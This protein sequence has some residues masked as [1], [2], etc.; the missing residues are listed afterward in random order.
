MVSEE[1]N[2][3]SLRR[4]ESGVRFQMAFHRE[5]RQFSVGGDLS[6]STG[7]AAQ[8]PKSSGSFVVN[9][10]MMFSAEREARLFQKEGGLQRCLHGS[11]RTTRGRGS[12]DRDWIAEEGN[13]IPTRAHS[14]GMEDEDDDERNDLEKRDVEDEGRI[15]QKDGNDD[16]QNNGNSSLHCRS[17]KV[18]QD[19]TDLLI[20][21]SSSGKKRSFHILHTS[22]YNLSSGL[23]NWLMSRFR[24]QERRLGEGWEQGHS[25]GEFQ[26]AA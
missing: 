17:E 15:F 6:G 12:E 20:R 19:A 13:G 10:E 18:R 21:H 16:N 11:I 23:I 24:I 14:D 4:A 5:S 3:V 8:K 1:I 7:A 22:L 9:D 2:F 25:H 26:R